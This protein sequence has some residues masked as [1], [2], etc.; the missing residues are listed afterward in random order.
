MAEEQYP[1]MTIDPE[2]IKQAVDTRT[3]VRLKCGWGLC[4]DCGLCAE[5]CH[6]Y[7][8]KNKDP[9]DGPV[10]KARKRKNWSRKRS[11]G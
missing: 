2:A 5:N 6:F 4:A 10:N 9:K 3:N 11:G 7:I 1:K 8:A